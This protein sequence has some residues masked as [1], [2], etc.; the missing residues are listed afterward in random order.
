MTAPSPIFMPGI[1]AALSGASEIIGFDKN[2]FSFL[3]TKKVKHQIEAA[4]KG[5][6][7][8]KGYSITVNS[9]ITVGSVDKSTFIKYQNQYGGGYG[10]YYGPDEDSYPA[11]CARNSYPNE[12]VR[13]GEIARDF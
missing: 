13:A 3:Y 5:N 8:G 11:P 7:K 12:S 6:K 2:P 4:P 1:I 9:G 10:P